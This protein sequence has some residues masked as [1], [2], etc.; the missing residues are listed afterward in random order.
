MPDVMEWGVVEDCGEFLFVFR[1][2]TI[3]FLPGPPNG[4]LVETE[5]IH[6]ANLGYDG[7]E[8][9]RALELAGGDEEATV[10]S[11]GDG[12]L[13]RGCVLISY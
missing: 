2:G 1:R 5:H 13:V 7:S 12:E 10:A 9:F 11:S 4:E 6:D 3:L 8:E